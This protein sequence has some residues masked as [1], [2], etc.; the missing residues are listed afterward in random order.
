MMENGDNSY[1][2][3]GGGLEGLAGSRKALADPQ[4]E[5]IPHARAHFDLQTSISEASAPV[6]RSSRQRGRQRAQCC[7]HRQELG[8]GYFQLPTAFS[9]PVENLFLP[10]V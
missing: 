7:S 1:G 9:F 3:P 2:P 5:D 10:E 4:L 6:S 8:S